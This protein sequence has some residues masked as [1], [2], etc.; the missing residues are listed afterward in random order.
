MDEEWP[1]PIS[2]SVDYQVLLNSYVKNKKHVGNGTL[3]KWFSGIFPLLPSS[4]R[5]HEIC[6]EVF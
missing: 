3:E 2:F 6:V 1:L 5:D 4:D